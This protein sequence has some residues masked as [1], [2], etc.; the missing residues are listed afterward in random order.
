[1]RMERNEAKSKKELEEYDPLVRNYL[2][3]AQRLFEKHKS[4]VEFW[5]DMSQRQAARLS[6][7][8]QESQL[9][10]SEE[11]L[12]KVEIAQNFEAAKN[13]F[14]Q[15]G[16]RVWYMTLRESSNVPKPVDTQVVN[17]QELKVERQLELPLIVN[18]DIPNAFKHSSVSGMRQSIQYIRKPLQSERVSQVNV[19]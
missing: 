6:R 8:P 15:F 16:T 10:R 14:E 1:M 17:G 4:T 5:D 18:E 19:S 12:Q 3:K 13:Q 11:Y 2:T 9:V 7:M